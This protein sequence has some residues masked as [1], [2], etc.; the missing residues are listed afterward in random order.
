MEN[1][2]GLSSELLQTLE[3]LFSKFSQ[4]QEV[5]IFGSRARGDYRKYSDID[6]AI[7]GAEIQSETIGKIR[8]ALDDLDTIYEFDLIHFETQTNEK[9]KRNILKEGLLLLDLNESYKKSLL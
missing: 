7:F 9:F 4:I 6:L 1:K 3:N 2:T 5:R 8:Q